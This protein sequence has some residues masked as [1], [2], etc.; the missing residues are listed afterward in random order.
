VVNWLP[1]SR[2]ALV[3]ARPKKLESGVDLFL[4]LLEGCEP[5]VLNG[6]AVYELLFE[7]FGVAECIASLDFLSVFVGSGGLVEVFVDG[8]TG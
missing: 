8:V 5:V 7:D 6:D 2:A 1:K 3:S 4:L